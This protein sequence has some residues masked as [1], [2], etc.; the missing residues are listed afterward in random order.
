MAK[1]LHAVVLIHGQGEQRPMQFGPEFVEH[2][3]LGDFDPVT[4][5]AASNPRV[6][7]KPEEHDGLDDVRRIEVRYD[8]DRPDLDIFEF[9]WAP[10]MAGNRLFHFQ[11]WFFALLRRPRRDLPKRVRWVKP[12]VITW[13]WAIF[14]M[15]L[16]YLYLTAGALFPVQI[17]QVATHGIGDFLQ[18][19][20]D[21]RLA[22]FAI[23]FV[24]TIAAF[25]ALILRRYGWC[26]SFCLTAALICSVAPLVSDARDEIHDD[27]YRLVGDD[28]PDH[29]VMAMGVPPP[30]NIWGAPLDEASEAHPGW[31]LKNAAALSRFLCREKMLVR[32][33][34]DDS[35]NQSSA[36]NSG[37][38]PEN[39]TDDMNSSNS[40]DDTNSFSGADNVAEAVW[41]GATADVNSID[42]VSSNAS[43][44][45]PGAA[46]SNG[47]AAPDTS[48]GDE[49]PQI[50]KARR[51][52]DVYS[53]EQLDWTNL[54]PTA[55][56]QLN[57]L[58]LAPI[59]LA[60]PVVF[61]RDADSGQVL[62]TIL[63]AI[64]SAVSY[65]IWRVSIRGFLVD[66][67]GDSARYLNNIP[68]NILAR[69]EIRKAGVDMI[70]RLHHT[71]RYAKIKVFAHSLGSIVAY[72]VLRQYWGHVA[73]KGVSL[74]PEA[75]G[76]L[77]TE[78]SNL[79]DAA[80]PVVALSAWRGAQTAAFTTMSSDWRVSDFVTMGAPLTHGRLL[81]EGSPEKPHASARFDSQRD[82]TRG[83]PACPPVD[84]AEPR[85]GLRASD[86]FMVVRW[87]N[88]FFKD[89][90]VG[91]P[92]VADSDGLLFGLGVE[93]QQYVANKLKAP[94][95]SHNSYWRSRLK[96][97]ASGDVPWLKSLRALLW[98]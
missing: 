7:W 52:V 61:A 22:I 5:S 48:E 11:R 62:A 71:D 80:D 4:A 85:E 90:I 95:I 76:K 87:T 63:L 24:L 79:G 82:V 15:L 45:G 17:V 54:N 57:D 2:V 8:D 59:A 86:M 88:L 36:S 72:D 44:M 13:V 49:P 14:L 32:T 25:L 9:Y 16:L 56:G 67:M 28:N 18:F 64:F 50:R 23:P 73:G 37:V 68:E 29:P 81:M 60:S 43:S 26:L 12:A 20:L 84:M 70:E 92:L 27:T 96:P 19:A 55:G 3:L 66:I 35:S 94:G 21:M 78:A 41:L 30:Y 97:S 83:M 58:C 69:H 74:A 39:W 40:I 91:G 46:S 10:K 34:N 51:D 53:T 1:E 47:E 42:A 98:H 75:L 38:L 93:D 89:D 65:L 33:S 77:R 6:R 31:L